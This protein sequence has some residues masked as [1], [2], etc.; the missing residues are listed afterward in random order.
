MALAPHA[1]PPFFLNPYLGSPFYSPLGLFR[2][3]PFGAIASSPTSALGCNGRWREGLRDLRYSPI[4]SRCCTKVNATDFVW[5]DFL[6]TKR[7]G[8]KC[9]LDE[10]GPHFIAHYRQCPSRFRVLTRCGQTRHGSKE[11]VLDEIVLVAAPRPWDVSY[12]I[13]ESN[14]SSI[15]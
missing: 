13:D 14:G 7:S 12:K 1:T 10:L 2:L 3:N 9:T 15:R 6:W 5:N 8:P 4:L 11:P